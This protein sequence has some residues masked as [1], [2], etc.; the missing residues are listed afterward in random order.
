MEV[1]EYFVD[2]TVLHPKDHIMCIRK[3]VSTIRSKI[4]SVFA[5]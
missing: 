5:E 4:A 1:G 2:W 3:N